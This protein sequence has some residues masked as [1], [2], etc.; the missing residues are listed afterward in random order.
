MSH[1]AGLGMGEGGG[2]GCGKES[3]TFQ[4]RNQSPVLKWSTQSHASRIK[5]ADKVSHVLKTRV[6]EGY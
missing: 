6:D 3:T 4:G 2:D 5:K 1:N